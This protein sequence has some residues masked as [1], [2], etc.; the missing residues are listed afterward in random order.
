MLSLLLNRKRL[1]ELK[2]QM[3]SS[4][5]C[6]YGGGGLRLADRKRNRIMI[7]AYYSYIVMTASL[8]IIFPF[9]S[10]EEFAMPIYSQLPHL[11]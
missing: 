9:I 6:E 3:L 11:K 8:V 7:V 2:H 4:I 10:T 5:N 1:T